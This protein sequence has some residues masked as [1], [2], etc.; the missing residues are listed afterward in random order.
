MS[1]LSTEHVQNFEAQPIICCTPTSSDEGCSSHGGNASRRRCS[2]R[3]LAPSVGTSTSL[4]PPFPL[5][6]AILDVFQSRRQHRHFR[7]KLLQHGGKES[8]QVLVDKTLH[9]G[10]SR[11]F[12][13]SAGDLRKHFFYVLSEEA[14]PRRRFITAFGSLELVRDGAHCSEDVVRVLF[15]QGLVELPNILLQASV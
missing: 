13:K 1:I 14:E 10:L 6:D 8:Q 4:L 12:R 5:C 9:F 3:L 15:S 11:V 2:T 7:G